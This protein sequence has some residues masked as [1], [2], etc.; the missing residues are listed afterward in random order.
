MVRK[1]KITLK[2]GRYIVDGVIGF[3]GGKPTVP[4]NM[5]KKKPARS[6]ENMAKDHTGN[7]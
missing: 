5:N 4:L 1:G 3:E 6:H 7:S 2:I